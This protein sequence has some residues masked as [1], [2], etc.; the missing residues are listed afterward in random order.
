MLATLLALA[1]EEAEPSKTAFYIAG[2]V[3]AGFAVLLA[4]F[5]MSRP[6]F[7]SSE[8]AARATMGVSA[9]LVVTAMVTVLLTS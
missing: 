9:L 8:G 4:A 7:P 1:S 2:S 3:L 5:G 6:D